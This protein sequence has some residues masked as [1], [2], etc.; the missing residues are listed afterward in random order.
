[1]EVYVLRINDELAHAFLAPDN[2]TAAC[3]VRSMIDRTVSGYLTECTIA[4]ATKGA[5]TDTAC[6]V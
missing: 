6:F 1:M 2:H 4:A 5:K 3:V